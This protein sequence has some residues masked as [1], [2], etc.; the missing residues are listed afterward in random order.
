MGSFLWNI[1]GHALPRAQGLVAFGL[2]LFLVATLGPSWPGGGAK[3]LAGSPRSADAVVLVNS[4]SAGYVDFTQ[5][6]RPYLDNFGIPYAVLDVATAPVT[7]DLSEHAVVL[8]GHRSLDT[9][10]TLLDPAEQQRIVD[11]VSLGVGLVSFDDDLATPANADRYSFMR[12]I[13]GF[14]YGGR[15]SFGQY[16]NFTVG[17]A[18]HWV[19]AL[20]RTSASYGVRA[21]FTGTI[22]APPAAASVLVQFP[23]WP[24]NRPLLVAGSFGQGRAIQW[25]A[26]DWMRP[27]IFGQLAGID[28][29][30]WRGIVWA[31]R[32]P[33]A[34]RGMPP[35]ITMRIDDTFGTATGGPFAYVDTANRYGFRPWLGLLIDELDTAERAA[36]ARVVLAGGATASPHARTYTNFLYWDHSGGR[37]F[38]D[39]QVAANFASSDAFFASLGIP[40]STVVVPHFYEIG[41]NAF[42]GLVDRGYGYLDTTIPPGYA[43]G[44]ATPNFLGWPYRTF[45]APGDNTMNFNVYFADWLTI[46]PDHP[47]NGRFF[48]AI[49]EIRQGADLYDFKPNSNVA[50]SIASGTDKLKRALD[51]M[52]LPTLFLHEQNMAGLTSSMWDSILSG[53]STNIAGYGPT[54]VTLDHAS[55]YV[56]ATRTSTLS[57]ATVNA[58]GDQLAVS[59]T[60]AADL[61]TK[62]WLFSGAPSAITGS[63]INVA[64]FTAGTTVSVPVFT[65]TVAPLSSVSDPVPGQRITSSTYVVSGTADDGSGSGVWRVDVSTDGGATWSPATGTTSWSY[66]W[67]PPAGPATIRSRAVDVA[68]NVGPPSAPVSVT[69]DDLTPPVVSEISVSSLTNTAATISWTTNEPADSQVEYGTTTTYGT[70]S[71]LDG[72]RVTSHSVALGALSA[73]QTYHYR[74]RSRDAAGNLAVSSDQTLT[75]TSGASANS[76][77]LNGTSAYA[78][79]PNASEL[80]NTG[81]WTLE[82]WFKDETPAGYNHPTAYIV[83]KGDTNSNS[84]APYFLGVQWNGL[85][86]GGR[87][88]W[89][90]HSVTYSLATTTANAW[91]HAA[92][93]F[94]ASSRQVT[95]YLDGVQVAQ[96]TLA[97]RTATGNSLPVGIGRNGTAG[98]FWR[99]KIDDVRIWNIARGGA[100][101]ASTFGTELSAPESGLIGNWRFDEGAGS[102]AADMAGVPQNAM[103]VG[104][105]SWSSDAGAAAAGPPVPDTNPPAVTAITASGVSNSG[106]TI[107]WTTDEPAD[108]QVDYGTTSAY[109]S[110]TTL[111][112]TLVVTHSSSIGGLAAAQTYHYRVRSRDAAGN[113]ATSPD[114]TFT[115]TSTPPASSLDLSGTAAYAVAPHATELNVTG[116]WTVET[117]FKDETPGGYNHPTT[118][119]VMKGDTNN[120]SE[121]PFLVGIQWGGL[122]AGGRTAWANST[123]SAPLTVSPSSWHHVAAVFVASTRQLT[124]YLD[125]AQVAQGTLAARTTT[126]NALPVQIGRNGSGGDLWRGKIDDLRIWDVARTASQVAASY[127]TQLTSPPAGLV[128][129]WRFDEGAGGTAADATT[130]PQHASL[131]GSAAWS[132]DIHP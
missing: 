21:T 43:H 17:P 119:L 76:L 35:L 103:L 92:A 125:G 52:V 72:A 93:V 117:W 97:A 104:A 11:A 4:Q 19:T 129:N 87:T 27:T 5:L 123:L 107:T 94:V 66:T 51:Q 99:G 36:L 9:A 46:A 114:L 37:P 85:F 74:V 127:R 110:S 96:G 86:A 12:S 41:A 29:L 24:A 31:A 98:G 88:A 8:I 81:D 40:H 78:E 57:G 34:I 68:G 6:V 89:A 109:G 124:L 71:A 22:V 48:N 55:Q 91:H 79:A 67:S 131:S 101:I 108:T 111:D 25:T 122:F 18:T 132:T 15:Y 45:T 20:Q 106:A 23:A 56:R 105:A 83:M 39:A 73:G 33:F 30:V 65:D 50:A 1:D 14:S 44:A 102:T 54:Y 16:S 100:N 64:P 53:I 47:L 61:E 26:S 3:A 116:D 38:T 69:V 2:C 49:T 126:G 62:F 75:T 128:A 13:W 80:N 113:L 120:N 28:D 112:G 63:L 115:T 59:F 42:Q 7:S 60:G 84:E 70:L 10:G 121:A 82:A 130:P 95:L 32:K 118:Y 58:A 77:A 90:N